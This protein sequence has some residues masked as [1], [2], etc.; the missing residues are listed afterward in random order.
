MLFRSDV[1]IG[2]DSWIGH[3]VTILSGVTIGHGAIVA[4]GALVAKDVP[5]YAVVGGVPARI[6]KF[7]FSEELRDQLGRLQWW[8]WPDR[9]IREAVPLLS[10][11]KIEDFLTL[12]H[13]LDAQHLARET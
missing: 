11:D 4:A 5:P 1:I 13:E 12:A 2:P 7:R 10:G 9:M 8:N 3:G 6:L